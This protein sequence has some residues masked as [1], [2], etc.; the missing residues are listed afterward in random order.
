M[1]DPLEHI[2]V[3]AILCLIL[4]YISYY[5]GLATCYVNSGSAAATAAV[6]VP[7]VSVPAVTAPAAVPEKASF[8]SGL[9]K[10]RYNC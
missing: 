10:N 6:L 7:A 9:K 5:I 2:I 3:I 1:E 8:V 4:I